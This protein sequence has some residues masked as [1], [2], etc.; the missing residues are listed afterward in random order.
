MEQAR[1]LFQDFCYYRQRTANIQRIKKEKPYM[2]DLKETP[3][4]L[5]LFARM[6]KWCEDRGFSPSE[7]LYS[8][9]VSRRWLF[10]PKLDAAHLQSQK[11][12]PK[13]RALRDHSFYQ[14]RQMERDSMQAPSLT[15]FDPNRD[16][17]H[18]AEN[19]KRTYLA[20]GRVDECMARMV[21]ETFGYH[22]RS[23]VCVRCPAAQVCLGQLQRSVAF[24]VLALRQGTITS[25]QARGQALNSVQNYGR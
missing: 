4:R 13:Y 16:L 2:R 9:F 15:T 3:V 8:L 21:V 22:P 1:Q 7:W 5:K 19:A 11:H 17:S 20:S 14:E 12:I 6:A 24:D 23:G 18:A 25:E 10:C